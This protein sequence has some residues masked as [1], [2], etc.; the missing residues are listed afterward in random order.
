[1]GSADEN[2]GYTTEEG[3]HSDIE[4]PV[5]SLNQVRATLQR[6]HVIE[7]AQRRRQQLQQQHRRRAAERREERTVAR[8]QFAN[9][10]QLRSVLEDRIWSLRRL[11]QLRR[12][13]AAAARDFTEENPATPAT[14]EDD[15]LF[16]TES[17]LTSFINMLRRVDESIPTSADWCSSDLSSSQPSDEVRV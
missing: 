8:E 12:D 7:R 10:L 1:M 15:L 2:S 9:L 16:V 17:R 3:S 14:E 13:F 4:A 5:A 6:R 11:C